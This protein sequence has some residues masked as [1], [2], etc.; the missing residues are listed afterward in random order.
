MAAIEFDILAE[1]V[2]GEVGVMSSSSSSTTPK[3][4]KT[5]SAINTG[6]FDVRIEFFLLDGRVVARQTGL[7]EFAAGRRVQ[8][9]LE[10]FRGVRVNM[11]RFGS[12]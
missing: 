8:N 10:L 2:S 3:S 4:T 11:P 7:N 12:D 6:D 9:R 5:D 1:A